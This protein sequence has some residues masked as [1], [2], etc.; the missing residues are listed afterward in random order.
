M[1][2]L[3]KQKLFLYAKKLR[4]NIS[5]H[6]LGYLVILLLSSISLD[7]ISRISLTGLNNTLELYSS[8]ITSPTWQMPISLKLWQLP[9]LISVVAL[10]HLA[11]YKI[12]D[13][14]RK[15]NTEIDIRNPIY[16]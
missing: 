3:K 13:I 4:N 11:I 16:G 8:I 9:I 10:I 14:I 1:S 2:K 7:A 6:I 5:N 12:K 15:P